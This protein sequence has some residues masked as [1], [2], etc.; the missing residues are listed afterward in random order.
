VQIAAVR[1]EV[2]CH[3]AILEA[4]G[5]EAVA[6][7]DEGGGENLAFAQESTIAVNLFV[8]QQEAIA[9]ANV[10]HEVDVPAKDVGELHDHRVA[11]PGLFAGHEQRRVDHALSLGDLGHDLP[12]LDIDRQLTAGIAHQQ[13]ARLVD[14]IAHFAQFAVAVGAEVEDVARANAREPPGVAVQREDTMQQRDAEALLAEDRVERLAR[15]HRDA[16]PGVECRIPAEE[17][18]LGQQQ[19]DGLGVHQTLR[20]AGGFEHADQQTRHD[21]RQAHDRQ[22]APGQPMRFVGD[23]IADYSDQAR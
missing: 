2:T 11:Q 10:Q 1:G 22:L 8:H 3:V 15:T 6:L 13:V 7:V 14:G 4:D 20:R 18:L 23:L 19:A 17:L 5:L 12:P 9:L 21:Q 16:V